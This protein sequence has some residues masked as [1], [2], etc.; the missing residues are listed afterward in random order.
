MFDLLYTNSLADLLPCPDGTQADPSLGCVST[1]SNILNP[2]SDA[3]A[4][5]VQIATGLSVAVAIAA[6][7]GILVGGIQYMLAL[8]NDEKI[9]QAKRNLFWS[10]MGLILSGMAYAVVGGLTQ[11][12]S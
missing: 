2:A 1:P 4:W 7:I 3:A 8:G 6:T 11:W 10:V 12:L 5:I 9:Q